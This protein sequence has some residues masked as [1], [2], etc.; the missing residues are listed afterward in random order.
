MELITILIGII[1][2]LPLFA[3]LYLDY[4]GVNDFLSTSFHIV[5]IGGT[6]L[7]F[8]S[9][10]STS[11]PDHLVKTTLLAYTGVISAYI[12]R[13]SVYSK[14]FDRKYP[15]NTV[16]I[17]ENVDNGYV[18]ANLNAYDNKDTINNGF[19]VEIHG[20]KQ[21]WFQIF[22]DEEQFSREVVTQS[23]STKCWQCD[24]IKDD[25]RLKG[26]RVNSYAMKNGAID[27]RKLKTGIGEASIC[28]DCSMELVKK[29]NSREGVEI[30]TA[31]LVAAGI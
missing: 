2:V 30:E 12:L 26:I 31:D 7:F 23:E 29:M 27:R 8:F 11:I 1:L 20:V 18:R 24:Q 3:V 5:F 9:S 6:A 19:V 16:K 14:P 4:T 22:E 21:K 15:E 28:Y 10:I 17:W 25:I 13:S